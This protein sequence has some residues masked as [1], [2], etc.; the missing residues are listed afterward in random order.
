M[1]N[2]T[3]LKF[4]RC[5]ANQIK[6]TLKMLRLMRAV[7]SLNFRCTEVWHHRQNLPLNALTEKY[8][9]GQDRAKT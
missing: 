6:Y 9:S 5:I 8:F 7:T 2:S 3:F 4:T 1:P